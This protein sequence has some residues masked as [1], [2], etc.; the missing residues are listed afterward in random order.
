MYVSVGRLRIGPRVWESPE[1]MIEY[2][3]S[4]SHSKAMKFSRRHAMTIDFRHWQSDR[5]STWPE[6]MAR[7]RREVDP[8]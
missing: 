4:G 3:D 5:V 7:V 2:R 6:A 8:Q 1:R